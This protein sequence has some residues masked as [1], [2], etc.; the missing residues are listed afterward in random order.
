MYGQEGPESTSDDPE[1]LSKQE[2]K[3]RTE[4]SSAWLSVEDVPQQ[5]YR[6]MFGKDGD[7][8]VPVFKETSVQSSVDH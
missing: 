6:A 7:L 3:A 1:V 5:A 8:L 4:L 2:A